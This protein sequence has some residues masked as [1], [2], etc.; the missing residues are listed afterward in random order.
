[1]GKK[2]NRTEH[3]AMAAHVNLIAQ[4]T[5]IHGNLH[6]K[7]EVRIEGYIKG[8]V[9]VD[10]KVV[11]APEGV[12]EGELH[13]IQ[14]DVAGKVQGELFIQERL[15]MKSTARIEGDV[16][17]QK[18]VIEEGAVFIGQCLMGERAREE[19]PRLQKVTSKGEQKVRA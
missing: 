6:A 13:A 2:R 9:V 18:L 5:E 12:I 14:A 16:R 15:V 4:G 3:H 10:G 19:A 7:S 17:T 8:H 1:M 11:L